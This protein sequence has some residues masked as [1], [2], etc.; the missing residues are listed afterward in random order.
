MLGYTG[1]HSDVKD[2]DLGVR[3]GPE[4]NPSTYLD[5]VVHVYNPNIKE[6]EAGGL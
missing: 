6:A 4:L 2:I 1:Y 3:D 5:I